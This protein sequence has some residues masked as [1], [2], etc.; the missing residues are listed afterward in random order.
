[1]SLRLQNLLCFDHYFD[2]IE[3]WLFGWNITAKWTALWKMIP[4]LQTH[5]G[6]K[7]MFS[8]A[9]HLIPSSCFSLRINSDRATD[10]L[11]CMM[12]PIQTHIDAFAAQWN[13][14]TPRAGW[15]SGPRYTTR[16]I[17]AQCL[18]TFIP[19]GWWTVHHNKNISQWAWGKVRREDRCTNMSMCWGPLRLVGENCATQW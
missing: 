2:G 16:H 18:Y 3:T 15:G 5:H 9:T 14:T 6:P 4:S 10:I 12:W 8:S 7:A 11:K 1:M 19:L 13:H 17:V